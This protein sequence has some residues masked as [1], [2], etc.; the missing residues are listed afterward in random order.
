M[1]DNNS[2]NLDVKLDPE[3]MIQQG[4]H[5]GHN[6][7]KLH[8]DMEPYLYGI[9]N[10][11]NIIDLEKTSEKLKEALKFIKKLKEND[12]TLLVVGTK[13]Q[14]Q[15]LTKEFAE[16]CDFPY[17]NERWIGGTFTNFDNISKRINYLK[18]LEQQQ[19][20]G[21]F[22]KYTKKEKADKEEEIQK[23]RRKFGGLKE[24]DGL[25]DA[26]LVL[27]MKKDDLAVKEA[28]KK[29][30]KIVGIADT[31]VDPTDADY[32]IPAN[33]DAITSVQ[34]ILEKIKQ[35]AKP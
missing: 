28:K 31:N 32:P 26:V 27:H 4:V 21:E 17:V 30:V 20:E 12:K 24:L 6:P 9:R 33:D 34:Y 10:T 23:L 1:S 5:F 8:P 19:E 15:D 11:I 3:E 7:S 2:N 13:I 35:V 25:P 14:V 18:D 29:G 16:E 22:E